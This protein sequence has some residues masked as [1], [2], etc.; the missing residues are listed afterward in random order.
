MNTNVRVGG[1]KQA[2]PELALWS[3][4]ER[5]KEAQATGA[6]ALV[7]SCPWC[8]HNFKDAAREFGQDIEIYD[9][10]EI[11]NKAL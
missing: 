9:L 4:N 6:Q 11:V 10:A 2:N 1:V 8:E 5:I 7:T 3:A